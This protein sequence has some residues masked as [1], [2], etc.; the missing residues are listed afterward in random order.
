MYFSILEALKEKDLLDKTS[1]NKALFKLSK[2]YVVA[3][4]IRGSVTKIFDKSQKIATA[5]GLKLYPKILLRCLNS[6]RA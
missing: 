4:G 3:D 1:V 5:F 2:I 6:S